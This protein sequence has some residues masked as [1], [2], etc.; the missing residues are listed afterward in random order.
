MRHMNE[1]ED[2]IFNKAF[3]EFIEKGESIEVAQED[4]IQSLVCKSY[5]FDMIVEH[6]EKD[7]EMI[8]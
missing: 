4:S 3:E 6:I 1:K 7:K 2:A 8:K 5:S